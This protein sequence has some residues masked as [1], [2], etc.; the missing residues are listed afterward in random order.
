[1]E[2]VPLLIQGKPVGV[3][4]W[5]EGPKDPESGR[6]DFFLTPFFTQAGWELPDARLLRFFIG[7]ALEKGHTHM[8][9]A[10]EETERRLTDVLASLDFQ[11]TSEYCHLVKDLDASHIYLS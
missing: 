1:M 3:A 10:A 7:L 5:L 11:P 2:F 8:T 6:R 4:C 9:L